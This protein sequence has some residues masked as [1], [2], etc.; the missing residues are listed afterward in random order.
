M[1]ILVT[2][3]NGFIGSKLVT[4]LSKDNRVVG[5]THEMADIPNIR[6]CDLEIQNFDVVYHLASTVDNYHILTNPYLDIH[7]NC[8][9][10]ISVL[11]NIKRYCPT[12]KL[13][14]ASTFFVNSGEPLGLYGASKLFSEHACNIYSKVFKLHV[15]TARL[16]NVYGPGESV[17]N[18]KKNAFMRLVNRLA[19]NQP[20]QIYDEDI[21]RDLVYIDDVIDALQII[22]ANGENR[23]IYTVGT[24]TKH[25]FKTLL[26]QIQEYFHSSSVIEY[27]EPPDFHKAVGMKD[28]DYEIDTLKALGWEPKFSVW[29][30]INATF[31]KTTI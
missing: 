29:D 13:I 20:I 3:A 16:C 6:F 9:G 24:G 2:G 26:A 30:G 11:E 25:L 5:F 21:Y 18:N 14:F 1:N 4:K 10:T 7:T 17:E 15:C 28:L 8:N 19:H 31:N 12:A 27:V 23:H 22:A